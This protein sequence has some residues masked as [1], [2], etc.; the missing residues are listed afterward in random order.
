MY[1]AY[2]GLMNMRFFGEDPEAVAT[3]DVR[4]PR[5]LRRFLPNGLRVLA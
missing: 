1:L 4:V 3:V 2:A 5:S